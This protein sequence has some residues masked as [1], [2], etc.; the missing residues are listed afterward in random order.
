[1]NYL[2]AE[3]VNEDRF[4]PPHF[5]GPTDSGADIGQLPNF[6]ESHLRLFVP[7]PLRSD[8]RTFLLTNESQAVPRACAS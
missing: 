3:H 8:V 1:M 5:S 7:C 4:Q 6:H 2:R